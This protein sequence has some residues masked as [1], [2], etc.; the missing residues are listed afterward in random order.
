MYNFSKNFEIYESDTDLTAYEMM[1]TISN[2]LL[3]NI[4]YL[5][6]SIIDKEFAEEA[7]ENA[8]IIIVSYD[9]IND[10]KSSIRGFMCIEKDYKPFDTKSKNY[11][12]ISLICNAKKSTVNLRNN[13]NNP[14]G[15]D[16]L[17]W[18]IN[19]GKINRYQG[20]ALKALINVIPYYHK[21]GWKFITNLNS[22]EKYYISDKVQIL[23]NFIKNI[24][25]L[26]DYE[27]IYFKDVLLPFKRYLTDLHCIN[28]Q[29]SPSIIKS[30]RERMEDEDVM[31]LDG[32]SNEY[33]NN[34]KD[35]GWLMIYH[36]ID[37]KS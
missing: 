22:K 26:D 36:Y 20:I 11:L 3:Y 31:D 13:S 25:N 15:K 10:I 17:N 7:L 14:S 21:L 35:N 37:D 12:Y 32:T 6:N 19:Y 18:I 2:K 1:Y 34:I 29:T 30:L 27:Y 8:D 23:Y 5:S 9:T 28:K 4:K 16:M 33:L 24:K